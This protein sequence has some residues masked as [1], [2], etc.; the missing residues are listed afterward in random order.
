MK[1]TTTTDK[2]TARPLNPETHSCCE[3]GYV[4]KHYHDGSHS[5]VDQLKK[6]INLLNAVAEAAMSVGLGVEFEKELNALHD[7]L[8]ALKSFREGGK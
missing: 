2:A 4:W 5:C 1:T 6:Q 8:R 7:T 3:C